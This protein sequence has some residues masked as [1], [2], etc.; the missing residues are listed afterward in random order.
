MLNALNTESKDNTVEKESKIQTKLVECVQT[1][2]IKTILLKLEV[3]SSVNLVRELLDKA[4]KE[5]NL[6][7]DSRQVIVH[8]D[9]DP[10]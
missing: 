1:L 5:M 2:Y 6:F 4:Q 10:L 3:N 7:P 9:V 8:Y